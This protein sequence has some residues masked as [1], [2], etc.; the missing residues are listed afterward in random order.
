MIVDPRRLNAL[1]QFFPSSVTIQD[2]T[3]VR[4]ATGAETRTYA[5][6]YTNL[7]CAIAPNQ[8]SPE[9]AEFHRND[10]TRMRIQP[11]IHSHHCTIRGYFPA[12]GAEMRA[13]SGGVTYDIVAVEHDSQHTM[14][15]LR[16]RQVES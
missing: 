14:T 3:V 1:R 7:P 12:I 8:M 5:A 4:T 16:M 11:V 10:F 13:T 2:Y 6:L 9:E 15:R